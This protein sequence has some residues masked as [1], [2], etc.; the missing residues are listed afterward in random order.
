[1]FFVEL[2]DCL[3]GKLLS[4]GFSL[5]RHFKLILELFIL[6]SFL[7]FVYSIKTFQ[8]KGHNILCSFAVGVCLSSLSLL[9]QNNLQRL[10]K[11]PITGCHLAGFHSKCPQWTRLGKHFLLGILHSEEEFL[12]NIKCSVFCLTLNTRVMDSNN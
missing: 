2:V 12:E 8:F 9:T 7:L 6:N 10:D 5:F 4:I 3:C 1:M 11:C